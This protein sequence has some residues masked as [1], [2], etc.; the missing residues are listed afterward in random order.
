MWYLSSQNRALLMRKLLHLVAAVVEDEG[1]P[2]A[3]LA[4]ARV[5]VFVEMGAVEVAEAVFVAREVGR[6]PVEDDAD[7][8]LVQ[9][10]DEEHE[11]LRRAEAAGRGEVADR[12]IAPRGVEA[13]AP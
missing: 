13:D 6:H 10:V 8:A 3:V 2:V 7:A 4:E 11:V 9:R 12:L 5:G 1:A